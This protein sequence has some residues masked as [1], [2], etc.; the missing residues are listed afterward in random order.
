MK[1]DLLYCIG[2]SV[3]Y[4]MG[5]SDDVLGTVTAENRFSSLLGTHYGLPVVNAGLP[6][7]ANEY[8]FRRLYI[9]MREFR[10]TNI[11]P[12]VFCGYT[13]FCRKELFCEKGREAAPLNITPDSPAF[14]KEFVKEYFTNH[15]STEHLK[16]MS[17][18]Q[19]DACKTLLLH[20]DIDYVDAWSIN[21]SEYSFIDT[22]GQLEKSIDRIVGPDHMFNGAG[23]LNV[24]GNEQ[25][26][27]CIINKISE[28]YR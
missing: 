16:L 25:I 13:D 8:I 3:T 22:K 24:A 26:A 14:N 17:D 27:R 10:R 1:Y 12:L 6:G 21:N 9:D 2:D 18:V 7:C 11:T 23:H 4:A 19:I 15:Y 28:V 5:Q 20:L